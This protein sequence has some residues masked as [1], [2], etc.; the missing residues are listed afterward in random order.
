MKKRLIILLITF[1]LVLISSQ[2]SLRNNSD[3][4]FVSSLIDEP[5]HNNLNAL[6]IDPNNITELQIFFD[7]LLEEHIDDYYF[8]GAT[9][10]VV[11][12]TDLLYLKGYGYAN[13]AES[14]AVNPNTSMFRAASVSK[15]FVWTAV[16]QLFEEG[17]FDLNED[18]NEYLTTFKIPD[19]FEPITMYDIMSHSS[20]FEVLWE[21]NGEWSQ[22][23][24]L[25]SLEDYLIEKMPK[26][27]R[28]PG[29]VSAY[30]NY[31]TTLA[32]YIVGEISGK[33][34]S[35]YVEDEI[36]TPLGMDHSTFLQPVPASF[37]DDLVTGYSLDN[38]GILVPDD[39]E[40]VTVYPTGGLSMSALDAS[41]FMR[42][43][44]NN[45]T[46]SATEMLNETTALK[47]QTQHYT[48]HPNLAGF[49]HGFW[50]LPR[51]GKR[52]LWHSG[53]LVNSQSMLVLIPDEDIGFYIN[54]NS[55][56]GNVYYE[57]IYRFV[58]RFFP[59]TPD[60]VLPPD[61]NLKNTGKKF[62]GTYRVTRGPWSTP[63]KNA[64]L[65]DN[66]AIKIDD[67]GYL[68]VFDHYQC[69][70]IDDLLFQASGQ[71]LLIGFRENAKGKITHFFVGDNPSVAFERLSGANNPALA[72]IISMTILVV[73][74]GTQ[75]YDPI[76]RKIRKEEKYLPTSKPEKAAILTTKITGWSI[77]SFVLLYGGLFGLMIVTDAVF[78]ILRALLIVPYMLAAASLALI[79]LTTFLWIKKQ[80][81]LTNRIVSTIVSVL[82]I[83]FIW[84][85][86][87]WNWI[88][89]FYS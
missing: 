7:D 59:N 18:V 69:V 44:L 37:V 35:Q 45:G 24:I 17:L 58:E 52:I 87:N 71:E 3:N 11:N 66:K 36:F 25:Y 46:F 61:A 81:T 85:M 13:I 79:G 65:L 10:S 12:A 88:G 15:L 40:Y 19:T 43:H 72:W 80:S 77:P 51:N 73:L 22:E 34:F 64:Y 48:H 83:I 56:P 49:A 63:S 1:N 8:P 53:D 78:P 70:Q 16:M 32:G 27:V 30:S 38:N 39:F 42:A 55:N 31:A 41:Y 89:S 4:L 60:P 74:I 50:E 47:M 29:E 5:D 6:A 28:P 68:I 57:V 84:W 62:V 82:S 75:V 54:Y 67:Q 14:E 2:F 21:R 76:R 86:F 33:P 9:L 20:G 26:R 23:G